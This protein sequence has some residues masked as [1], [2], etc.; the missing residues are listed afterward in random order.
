M[1]VQM[2]PWLAQAVIH[3]QINNAKQQADRVADDLFALLASER[4]DVIVF[5]E[6]FDEG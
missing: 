2:L 5:N 4:P 6:V 3:G 1:N